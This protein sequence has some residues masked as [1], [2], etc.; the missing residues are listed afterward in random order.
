MKKINYFQG[1]ILYLVGS[2]A[3]S[4]NNHASISHLT[5]E[6]QSGKGFLEAPPPSSNQDCIIPADTYTSVSSDQKVSVKAI[7]TT[8]SSF[9]PGTNIDKSFDGNL[10]TIY[11]SLWNA[12]VLPVVLNYRFDGNTRIDY[13]RYIPRTDGNTNGNFG[14]VRIS[15]NTKTVSNLITLLE[16]DFEQKSSPTKVVFPNGITPLNIQITVTN[17]AGGFVSCAEM[18]FYQAS[19]DTNS[20][21]NIFADDIYSQLKPGV[22]QADINQITSP[23]YK[24]L[25]Q[26]LFNK[27]YDLTYRVKNY[28]VYTPV[29]VLAKAL[30]T[31]T[32]SP[33]ENPTGI[34]FKKGTKAILFVKDLPNNNIS[35]RVRDFANEANSTDRSYK[36]EKGLNMIDITD[37]G[38]GYIN[39]YNNNTSLPPV[40]I[41][42]VSGTIN[43][44][45]NANTSTNDDWKTLLANNV[46]PKLDIIGQYTHLVYDKKPLQQ[47][48]PDDGLGF[49]TLYNNIVKLQHI[50]NGLFK[51]NKVPKNRMF[52]WTESKG[53]WYASGMGA[54]FDL[55]W[56]TPNSTSINK[57]DLW[58]V[59]H[60]FGHVNQIRPGLKWVGTSDVTNNIYSLWTTHLYGTG[61]SR[62]RLDTEVINDTYGNKVAGG[63]MNAFLNNGI[64]NGELWQFQK[65][66]D[67]MT[68]Y[69]N[70]GDLFVKLAPI[71]QLMLYYQLAG[72]GNSWYKPDWSADMAERVRNISPAIEATMSNGRMQLDFMKNFCDIVGED[73]TDFFKKA[74]MLKPV[75]RR[76]DDYTPAQLTITQADCDNLVAYASKYPKPASPVI[77]YLSINSVDAYKNKASIIGTTGVGVTLDGD[78]LTINHQQWKNVAAFETYDG[79]TLLRAAIY[80]TGT[81]DNSLTKIQLPVQNAS[82]YAVGWD[83]NKILVYPEV[84][85]SAAKSAE[86]SPAENQLSL[87]PNP[88]KILDEVKIKLNNAKGKYKLQVFSYNG[89]AVIESSGS[90]EELN[91]TMGRSLSKLTLGTYLVKLTS[92]DSGTTYQTKLIR[93]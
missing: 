73:L 2:F 93:Q 19:S 64:I 70:G 11:H 74:G 55:N 88:A 63:R 72:E 15:Y 89:K 58:G 47:N 53:G 1:I 44:I 71:W 4:A 21:A 57:L 52:A 32:Y 62:Y 28:E 20:Y 22:T 84:S 48:V 3:L 76:V 39:Y 42:I 5:S 25:A 56:G 41:N 79:S 12:T 46:Y 18:E 69:Q 81:R 83:G 9:Q 87:Y 82:V 36:L 90:I 67:K 77:Y 6:P 26:C 34:F 35:L 65:G 23:F 59:A 13:L 33:F 37:D 60:E 16:Y 50:Q 24:A 92:V 80:G 8:A 40:T 30:K 29:D 10:S 14:K 68:N 54:H 66:P 91:N 49:I 75:N 51:Y 45:F 43:G 7:G 31:S 78:V 85:S 17:G 38:L 86:A 61:H 27:T